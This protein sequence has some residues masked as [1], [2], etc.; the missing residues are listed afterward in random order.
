MDAAAEIKALRAL[1]PGAEGVPVAGRTFVFIPSIP[2]RTHAGLTVVDALLCPYQLD[3][4]GG[5][6]TKL[7][8]SMQVPS[9]P[10][11]NN[12]STHQY[13]GRQWWTVSWQGVA[14]DQGWCQ[15]LAAHLGAFA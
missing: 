1:Y 6:L 2:V 14:A 12:W 5:Y 3:S 8:L 15:I 7:Y 11:A 10:K 13:L 9:T 4:T